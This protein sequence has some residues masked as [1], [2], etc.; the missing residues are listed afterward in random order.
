MSLRHLMPRAAAAAAAAAPGADDVLPDDVSQ[1]PAPGTR[2]WHLTDQRR[3][4]EARPRGAEV[5]VHVL[6]VLLTCIALE[7]N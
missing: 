1:C 4:D 7:N 2:R 5:A 3:G 6:A